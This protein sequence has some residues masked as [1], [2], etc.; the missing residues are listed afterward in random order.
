[1]RGLSLVFKKWFQQWTVSERS[2]SLD[3][4]YW[5]SFQLSKLNWLQGNGPIPQKLTQILLLQHQGSLWVQKSQR[6]TDWS[7]SRLDLNSASCSKRLTWASIAATH[8]P[9]YLWLNSKQARPIR[10]K[11]IVKNRTNSSQ[12]K[13]LKGTRKVQKLHARSLDQERFMKQ[14]QL[15]ASAIDIITV[16]N[17]S[18]NTT[19]SFTSLFCLG[20]F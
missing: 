20:I 10:M 13:A 9:F 18:T 2:E 17:F 3:K 19:F 6:G 16:K 14:H 11:V 5:W 7:R 12:P 4:L 1:M 8:Q 15:W